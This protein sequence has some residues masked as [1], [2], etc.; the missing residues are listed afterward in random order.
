MTGRCSLSIGVIQQSSVSSAILS[1]SRAKS[2]T[3]WHVVRHA[4]HPAG[5]F[6][7]GE[8]PHASLGGGDDELHG[9]EPVTVEDEDVGPAFT[10]SKTSVRS[11]LSPVYSVLSLPLFN[12]RRSSSG[13]TMVAHVRE[14]LRADG[15]HPCG[16]SLL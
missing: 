4:R 8:E 7:A 11:F 15:F 13:S 10:T 3:A 12:S 6:F 9:R 16:W 2:G 5:Q 1:M 14:E